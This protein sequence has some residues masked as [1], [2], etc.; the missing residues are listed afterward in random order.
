M[1]NCFQSQITFNE[2]DVLGDCS[3]FGIMMYKCAKSGVGVAPVD[4]LPQAGAVRPND[5]EVQAYS[6]V[7]AIGIKADRSD[8]IDIMYNIVKVNATGDFW[9][10]GYGIKVHKSDRSE[11]YDNTVE[12]TVDMQS[13]SCGFFMARGIAMKRCGESI[14]E[15]NSVKVLGNGDVNSSF[16]LQ[17]LPAVLDEDEGDIAEDLAEF[18]PTLSETIGMVLESVE[19]MGVGSAV[20]ISVSH[21]ML[22]KVMDNVPVDVDIDLAIVAGDS[23]TITGGGGCAIGISGLDSQNIIVSG[24]GVDVWDQ[25]Y[26]QS[27]AAGPEGFPPE[28]AVA[29]GASVALGIIL[30]DSAMGMVTENSVNALADLTCYVETTEFDL[31]LEEVDSAMAR[32]DSVVLAAIEQ[33]MAESLNSES[34][35]VLVSGGTPE[36]QRHRWSG[37][38][39]GCG[40]GC[41]TGIGIMVSDSDGTKVIGNN[42]V[43][44]TGNVI[45]TVKSIDTEVMPTSAMANGEGLGLGIGIAIFD[46]MGPVVSDNLGV[47]GTGTADLDV[48]ATHQIALPVGP[49]NAE[50]DGDG[51]GIGVGILLVGMYGASDE[52]VV[53]DQCNFGGAPT[54]TGNEVTALGKACPVDISAADL[55]PGDESYAY[56]CGLGVG[57]GIAA[58][59]YPF[60]LIQG[61]LVNATGNAC[62]DIQ[63]DAVSE[64]DPYAN[65][66]AVGIGIGIIPVFCCHAQVLDNETT[67]TGTANGEVGAAEFLAA[68][69]GPDVSSFG[70]AFGLGMGIAVIGSPRSLVSGN[71][72]ADGLGDAHCNVLAT[73]E[74]PLNEAKACS[75]STGIGVGIAVMC[76]PCTDVIRCNTAAGAGSARVE[77]TVTADFDYAEGLGFAASLD[78]FL[79]LDWAQGGYSDATTE[80][81]A[82]GYHPF[83]RHGVVNYNSMVDVMPLDDNAGDWPTFTLDAGLLK[84]GCP[85]LDARYNWWNDPTGPSGMGPGNGEAVLWIGHPVL[86][87]P[88]LYVVH[89]DVLANQIGKFG[90]FIPMSKGL[91]T[92]STPIAL[93]ARPS[94]IPMGYHASLTWADIAFNSDLVNAPGDI[95][96]LYIDKWVPG[97]GWQSVGPTDEL[98]PLDAWYI[99]LTGPD[100][101]VI[102][103]V[104]SDTA[105]PSM[106]TKNLAAGWNLIGPNPM[107]FDD[108]GNMTRGMPVDDALVS[109]ETAGGGL[110]G[111]A[112]VISPIVNPQCQPSWYYVPGMHHAPDMLS[113][114]GYWVW[115]ENSDT[116]VG[117]GFSPIWVG[118]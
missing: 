67:G 50:A 94:V 68:M 38:A 80:L 71:S 99:Y 46:T 96:Y 91:N 9:S 97:T 113:G 73:T 37:L 64:F 59:C 100:H 58:A 62:V 108:W 45:A 98:T 110:Q 53:N 117:F 109:I 28:I 118:P 70:G 95:K 10:V 77:T 111:Y 112:Q 103:F 13:D 52:E 41:A 63:A 81:D 84:I 39:I 27:T 20:G 33:Q 90:F 93:E 106:P 85:F 2:L 35:N 19:A 8:L 55:I 76:S 4:G 14:I 57:L 18:Q 75:F 116:L 31:P 23:F 89:T 12:V 47:N 105:N 56:G 114:K 24:N 21:C 16:I 26:S 34:M 104:N 72:V 36:V 74:I 65:G 44:G 5:I 48:G 82:N 15:A 17:D 88:W 43:C 115:M 22:A 42:P 101:R 61:N 60:I 83:F 30:D 32:F 79:K 11:V 51:V 49:A 1:Y 92:L 66:G 6:D 29:G 40:D 78:M 86:F 69:H 25:V 54:V 7:L 87:E 3:A 102:L 107:F